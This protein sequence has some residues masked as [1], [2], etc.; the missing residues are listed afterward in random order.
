M[1]EPQLIHDLSIVTGNLLSGLVIEDDADWDV[2]LKDQLEQ[3]AVGSQYVRPGA[4]NTVP[5]SPYGDDW[6]LLWLGHCGSSF[7]TSETRRY[8][9]ENDPTVPPPNHRSNNKVPDFAA[10]G[11]DNS[12]RV[13][14]TASGG[15][16][17]Q[18]YAL[19]LRGARK[20]I[21]HYTN[22]LDFAPID[23]GLHSL[24]NSQPVGFKCIGIFPQIWGSHRSAGAINRDSDINT[25][26]KKKGPVQIRK[27]PMTFNIVYSMRMNAA[28]ILEHGIDAI[29]PQWDDM[30]TLNDS[31]KAR[32]D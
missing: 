9:I 24:C 12:S 4:N 27:K 10:A 1:N 31:L 14:Y 8:V 17:T 28:N 20:I 5:E 16:C 23:I 13:V 29:T 32:F 15:L 21:Q 3:L 30:P 26:G 7:S 2:H 25:S 22:V 11:Y 19:S 6:D 18:A